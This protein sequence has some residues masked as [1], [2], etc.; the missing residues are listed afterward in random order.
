MFTRGTRRCGAAIASLAVL[1]LSPQL[2]WAQQS[3]AEL[4]KQLSNPVA[5]LVSVPLQLNY[6]CCFGPD[7]GGRT[8]L[9]V[10]PVMPFSMNDDWN[11]VVRTIMPVIHQERTSPLNGSETGIGDITQS[12]FFS[13][14]ASPNGVTWAVGPAF[15][16][17]T[18]KG[19]LG[20]E[21]WAAGPTALVL[22]Q[23]GGWTYGMLA[24]HLWSYA[25]HGGPQRSDVSATFLQPFVSWTSENHTTIGVNTESTYDWTAEEW[26]VP[27]NLTVAHL[28]SFGGQKVQL[29]GGVKV[30]A[31]SPNDELDWGAR[32]VATFLFPK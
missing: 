18:A 17:P 8:T 13:P 7:D 28:Y 9:N 21:R 26:T 25:D 2:A 3:D 23:T 27:I 1:G 29:T 12:F 24:N 15:L 22:K 10:Q 5:S 30:Y 4:A 16:W 6:D 20:S 11:L 14:K 32:V 19:A 31:V